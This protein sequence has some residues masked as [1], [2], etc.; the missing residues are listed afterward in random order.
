[1]AFFYYIWDLCNNQLVCLVYGNQQEIALLHRPTE[2]LCPKTVGL[3]LHFA[4]VFIVVGQNSSKYCLGLEIFSRWLGRVVG[5]IRATI[6]RYT[7]V[8][9]FK[10]LTSRVGNS[11]PKG[12]KSCL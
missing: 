5:Y 4:G 3:G 11:V 9:L 6:V 12:S 2:L 10:Q 1:M 8:F 7:R